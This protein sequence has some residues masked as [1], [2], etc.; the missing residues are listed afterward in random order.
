MPTSRPNASGRCVQFAGIVPAAL[1]VLALRSGR[2]SL[3][4]QAPS[5]RAY[6]TPSVGKVLT[7]S[8]PYDNQFA[9]GGYDN[10]SVT[11]SA[12]Y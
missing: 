1:L 9:G 8:G 12:S 4:P 3:P 10:P 5:S 6:Y 2:P 11:T 7:N